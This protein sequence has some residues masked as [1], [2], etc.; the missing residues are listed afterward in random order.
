MNTL[1]TK[2]LYVGHVALNNEHQTPVICSGFFAL[3][4]QGYLII[5]QLLTHNV[6]LYITI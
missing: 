2:H 6:I 5:I 3:R 4:T 1:V